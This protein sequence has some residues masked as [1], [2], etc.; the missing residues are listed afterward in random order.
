MIS[1]LL[2]HYPLPWLLCPCSGQAYQAS[3]QWCA[4]E[5][6]MGGGRCPSGRSPAPLLTHWSHERHAAIVSYGQPV[7]CGLW[8][9]AYQH[10]TPVLHARGDL[11]CTHRNWVTGRL[12][13]HAHMQVYAQSL[14][15][16]LGVPHAAFTHCGWCACLPLRCWCGCVTDT[17]ACLRLCELNTD[18]GWPLTG[19]HMR[20]GRATALIFCLASCCAASGVAATHG[21]GQCARLQCVI[22]Q[23]PRAIAG[24]HEL[25]GTA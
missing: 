1:S 5:G 22:R 2:L 18:A 19:L 10:C 7:G 17:T 24:V 8:R 11:C 20:D 15:H 4:C 12:P 3:N 14:L 16:I 21:A 13:A 23:M 6:C 9:H 25:R